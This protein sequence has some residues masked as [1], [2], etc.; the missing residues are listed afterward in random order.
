MQLTKR[1]KGSRRTNSRSRGRSS[2]VQDAHRDVEQL[3]LGGLEQLVA[4]VGLD[5]V[6]QSLA[7]MAGR[8]ERG[9]VDHALD[10]AVEHGDLPRA[11]AVGGRGQQ[12]EKAV[13]ADHAAVRRE[14]LDPD[15]VEIGAAMYRAASVGL[16]DG[17]QRQRLAGALADLER[18]AAE[19]RGQGAVVGCAENAERRSLDPPQ[20]RAVGAVLELVAAAAQQGEVAVAPIQARNASASARLLGRHRGRSSPHLLQRGLDPAPH[21]LPVLHRMA[22]I[23]QH[24][25]QVGLELRQHLG[26]RLPIDLEQ[27]EAL[28]Q[29]VAD[30]LGRA[31]VDAACRPRRG[32]PPTPGGSPGG[33]SGR[34]G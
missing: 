13:L 1:A 17:Q 34:G 6:Q 32:A 11:H 26:A 31:E 8:R 4:R 2:Q 19:A 22:D 14:P 18:Q 10:L 24:P 28:A 27:H 29:P 3:V 7:G 15:E 5:D 20:L 21:R 25:A 23:A 33:C 12:A 30:L 9:A 16:G